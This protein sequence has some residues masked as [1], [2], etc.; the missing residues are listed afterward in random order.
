MSRK[1]KRSKLESEVTAG[2]KRFLAKRN[3]PMPTKWS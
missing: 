3:L 1:H 2:Y